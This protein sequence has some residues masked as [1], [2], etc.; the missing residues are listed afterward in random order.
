MC[1]GLDVSVL[2]G[3]GGGGEREGVHE[4]EAIAKPL[5]WVPV[6]GIYHLPLLHATHVSQP[7]YYDFLSGAFGPDADGAWER[8][9]L[10][11]A[12]FE[13]WEGGRV[14]LLGHGRGDEL[15]DWVQVEGMERGLRRGWERG[16]QGRRV[17]VLEVEGGHADVWEGGREM[18]RVIAVAVGM[19]VEAE[20]EGR[21][22]IG[23][24]AR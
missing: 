17:R 2:K 19:V 3:G 22:G 1:R 23:G 13:A 11:G 5:A 18:A 6:A 20:G 8:A 12:G 4:E 24:G 16:G 21:G 9:S 10:M 7:V 14:V 15:V